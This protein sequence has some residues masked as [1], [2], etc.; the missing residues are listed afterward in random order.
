M[1]YESLFCAPLFYKVKCEFKIGCVLL[2]ILLQVLLCFI[3]GGIVELGYSV[4]RR[5]F[6]D[7]QYFC[8]HPQL[9]YF[10]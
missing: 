5:N 7:I 2:Q 8:K 4:I 3:K 9:L 6:R 10:V 1:G